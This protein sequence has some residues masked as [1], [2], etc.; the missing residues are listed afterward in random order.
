MNPIFWVGYHQDT[1]DLQGIAPQETIKAGHYESLKK[2]DEQERNED[3]LV[4]KEIV[5]KLKTEESILKLLASNQSVVDSVIERLNN[6]KVKPNDL[7]DTDIC[8]TLM[9]CVYPNFASDT[10]TGKKIRKLIKKFENRCKLASGYNAEPL[11]ITLDEPVQS[12]RTFRDVFRNA[13]RDQAQRDQ[14]QTDQA[15]TDQAK[16]DQ[17]QTDQAQ[18]E[19]SPSIDSSPEKRRCSSKRAKS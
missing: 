1:T 13:Q 3:V 15:Q 14:A 9:T 16:T 19:P 8:Y 10:S 7:L 12:T 2:I 4:D 6:L 5:S 18:S 17:A 11:N